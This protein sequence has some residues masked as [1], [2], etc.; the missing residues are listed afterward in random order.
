MTIICLGPLTNV[1]GAFRRD[2][3]LPGQIGQMVIMGGA[4][5]GGNVTQAAEFNIYCDPQSARDV[6]R[7]P[8]TMTLIPLDITSQVVMTFS[9]LDKLPS[10]STKAG[11][12][13]RK[14]LPFAFRTHR[15]E[16]GLEGMYLHD[17]VGL[18]AAIH[19]ELF[20][21]ERMAADVETQGELTSGQTVF[22]R[23]PVPQWRHNLYVATKVDTA[24]VMDVVIRGITDAGRAG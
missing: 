21:T 10:E 15:Q 22:D 6:F 4:L 18:V 16:F 24:A 23:R 9:D 7:Q 1:A 17:T 2:P 14:I 8:S 12:L 3:A 5:A 11:K 13:L 19:P 20:A